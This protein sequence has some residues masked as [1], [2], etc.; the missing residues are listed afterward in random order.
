MLE[1]ELGVGVDFLKLLELESGVGILKNLPTPQPFLPLGDVVWLGFALPNCFSS[2]P[3][4]IK[5]SSYLVSDFLARFLIH[6]EGSFPIKSSS[7]VKFYILAS[8]GVISRTRP[9]TFYYSI[10]TVGR[11][12]AR[13]LKF[14]GNMDSTLTLVHKKFRCSRSNRKIYI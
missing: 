8:G 12:W 3:F 7:C 4:E 6:H 11:S 13:K 5:S 10:I 14:A 2:I 9:R 1:S